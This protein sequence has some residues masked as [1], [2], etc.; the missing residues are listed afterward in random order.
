MY[1]L[2]QDHNLWE[3]ICKINLVVYAVNS[4]QEYITNAYRRN[5]N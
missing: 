1:K 5:K 3:C 4:V 2:V